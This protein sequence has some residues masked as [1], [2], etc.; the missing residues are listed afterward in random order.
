MVLGTGGHERMAGGAQVEARRVDLLTCRTI[1]QQPE[2]TDDLV[3]DAVEHER[4]ARLIGIRTATV[5]GAAGESLGNET[6]PHEALRR[7]TEVAP[8][9]TGVSRELV[10]VLPHL[11]EPNAGTG[12]CAAHLDRFRQ[13][14]TALGSPVEAVAAHV[15]EAPAATEE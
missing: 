4:Q 8:N 10:M 6:D 9:S 7:A 1:S 14:V 13:V 11:R 3:V 12:A 5:V 2:V 15:H